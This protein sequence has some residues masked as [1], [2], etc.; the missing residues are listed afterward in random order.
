MNGINNSINNSNNNI[1]SHPNINS[2]SNTNIKLSKSEKI[3]SNGCSNENSRNGIVSPSVGCPPACGQVVQNT[4]KYS[5]NPVPNTN[6]VTNTNNSANMVLNLSSPILY[7]GMSSSANINHN[8]NNINNNIN[9]VNVN[10]MN[11]NSG[12]MKTTNTPIS[13]S[14]NKQ[15]IINNSSN[16]NKN[17]NHSHS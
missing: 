15:Y 8:I 17:I 4:A 9:N 5:A 7:A 11:N 2:N 1:V 6:I 3:V 16:N 10:V 13:N 14:N 12:L